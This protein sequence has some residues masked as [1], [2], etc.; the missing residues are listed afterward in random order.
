MVPR[1]ESRCSKASN[2]TPP[3]GP[4]EPQGTR[5]SSPATHAEPVVR[6]APWDEKNMKRHVAQNDAATSNTAATSPLPIERGVLL[7]EQ[8]LVRDVEPELMKQALRQVNSHAA[9]VF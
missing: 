5:G 1:P 8:D 2:R 6:E 3:Q 4:L 7:L 9:W